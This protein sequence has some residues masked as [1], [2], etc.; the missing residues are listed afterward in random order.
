M[1][2]LELLRNTEL[3][4]LA[5]SYWNVR[6]RDLEPMRPSWERQLSEYQLKGGNSE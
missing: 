6:Q 5:V 2:Q 4:G 3:W 1:Q